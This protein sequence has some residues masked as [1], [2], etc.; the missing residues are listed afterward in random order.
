MIFATAM[1]WTLFIGGQETVHQFATEEICREVVERS[2]VYL[3]LR[4]KNQPLDCLLRP[5]HDHLGEGNG[6]LLRFN[7]PSVLGAAPADK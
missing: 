5:D 6:R 2:A 4:F 3:V 7:G 1:L